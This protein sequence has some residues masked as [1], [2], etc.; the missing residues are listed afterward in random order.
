MGM[1]DDE[2]PGAGQWVPEGATLPELREAVQECRGCELYRDATQAVMGDGLKRARLV[3][4][5][6]QPGDQE[7][8]QGKPFVGPAGRDPGQGPGEAGIGPADTHPTNVG[9]NLP[10]R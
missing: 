3:L 2:R 5:G 4:L 7:D 10:W 1:A 6:E 9:K 8:R